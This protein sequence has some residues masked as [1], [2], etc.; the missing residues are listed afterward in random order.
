MIIEGHTDSNGDPVQNERLSRRR[1]AAVA[2][3]MILE[4]VALDRIESVGRGASRPIAAASDAQAAVKN[5]R[6]EF[7]LAALAKR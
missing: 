6:I 2:A 1:A 7:H 3:A 4:G 5:R